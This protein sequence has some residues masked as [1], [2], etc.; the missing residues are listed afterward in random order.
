MERS[1]F[2]KL[3]LKDFGVGLLV[4]VFTAVITFLY[5]LVQAGPIVFNLALLQSIGM[6]ALAAGL[7]FILNN[8]FTNSEGKFLTAERK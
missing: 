6:T 5:N 7:G 3:N 2:L 4:A 1:G 8:L